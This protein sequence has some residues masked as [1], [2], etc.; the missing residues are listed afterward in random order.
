[1]LTKNFEHSYIIVTVLGT[2]TK[3][4]FSWNLYI[5]GAIYR[6]YMALTFS[7]NLLFSGAIYE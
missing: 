5:S 1:M 4:F 2:E 3:S 6:A 7:W